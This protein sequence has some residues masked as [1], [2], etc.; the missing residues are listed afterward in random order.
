MKFYLSYPESWLSAH[1]G[2]RTVKEME[3][4]PE[5]WCR[6]FGQLSMQSS[7][8]MFLKPL[9]AQRERRIILCGTGSLAFVG[10]AATP[11]LRTKRGFDIQDYGTTEIITNPHNYF[12]TQKPTLLVFYAPIWK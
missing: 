5:M 11:W 7:W 6:L 9:L 4:Q 10:M 3:Y 2:L 1:F 12:H 8:H